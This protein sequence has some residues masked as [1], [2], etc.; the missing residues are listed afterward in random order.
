M[1]KILLGLQVFILVSCGSNS[2]RE[3]F[4][5]PGLSFQL[6]EGERLLSINPDLNADYLAS[7]DNA[8]LQIP[9]SKCLKGENYRLFIGI[10][11]STSLERITA[12]FQERESL[13]GLQEDT[14]SIYATY[15]VKEEYVVSY[16]ARYNTNLIYV[17]AVT[18]KKSTSDSLF[19]KAKLI[20]RLLPN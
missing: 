15:R 7:Q 8:S 16:A 10:P 17:L 14:N 4:L 12:I 19:S 11:Y 6:N 13:L 3:L 1:K 20:D 9:L 5:L 18:D 2:Q